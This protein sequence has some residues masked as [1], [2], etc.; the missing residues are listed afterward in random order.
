MLIRFRDCFD[1]FNAGSAL[2]FVW[3]LP[4]PSF[5]WGGGVKKKLR[6]RLSRFRL[7]GGGAFCHIRVLLIGLRGA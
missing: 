6:P 4:F 5:F 3:R 7:R 1:C 2:G